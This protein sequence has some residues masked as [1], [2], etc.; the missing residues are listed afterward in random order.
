MNVWKF[1]IYF[2]YIVGV[3][4]LVR[5][6]QS[7]QLELRIVGKIEIIGNYY[8]TCQLKFVALKP[9]DIDSRPYFTS[10]FHS[11]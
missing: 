3:G 1:K 2:S 9:D 5:L 10:N 4:G 11:N 8:S 6:T 7:L